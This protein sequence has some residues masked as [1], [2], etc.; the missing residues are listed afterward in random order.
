MGRLRLGCKSLALALYAVSGGVYADVDIDVRVSGGLSSSTD[1]AEYVA[2]ISNC[3]DLTSL[4]IASGDFNKTYLPSETSRVKG[5]PIACQLPFKSSGVGHLTT[6]ITLNFSDGSVQSHSE[7]F[8]SESTPPQ[9]AFSSVSLES[10]NNQQSLITTVTAT[11]D[12][13]I[14]FVRFSVDGIRASELRA[15]GGVVEEARKTA[16][17]SSAGNVRVYPTLEGQSSFSL[18]LPVENELDSDAI[19]HDGVVLLNLTAVDASGNQSS[20]SKI[21]FTGDDVAEVAQDLS[22]SPNKIVFTNL[23]ETATVIPSVQFQFRGLTALPGAGSGAQY[24]SSRPDLIAV[25]NG[26]VIY[27]LAETL[28]QPVVI[29]VSY[30]GLTPIDV[31]V[32]VDV[33]KTIT[34][35]Q[36]DDVD[37][38]GQFVINRL[39]QAVDIPTVFAV[40]SDGS[41]TEIGSQF[42][43]TYTLGE[44][45]SGILE[46]SELNNYY[47]LTAKA[48]ITQ[49]VPATLSISLKHQPSVLLSLPVHADDALPD[50][51]LDVPPSVIAG[52]TIAL[53]AVVADDVGVKEVQF[54]MDGAVVGTRDKA[55]YSIS[56]SSTEQ[57]ANRTLKFTA[58]A[59]DTAG[60]SNETPVSLVSIRGEPVA[61]LPEMDFEKPTHMQRLVEGTPMRMQVA[62]PFDESGAISYMNFFVD[63]KRVG[64]AYFPVIEEREVQKPNGQKEK[65]LYELWRFSTT[66]PDISTTETSLS[67]H[68]EVFAGNGASVSLPSKL[69]RV[70]QNRPPTA[71][72]RTPAPGASVSVGQNMDLFVDISDDTLSAGADVVLLVNDAEIER[73]RHEELENSGADSFDIQSAQK[74][75]SFPIVE[76]YLGN[77]L[78]FRV[79]ILDFHEEVGLSEALKIPVK[80]DQ[81]PSVAISHPVEGSQFVA[82]LPIELRANAVDDVA[83]SRVDFFVN[84]QLVGSDATAPFSVS[85]ET[86]KAISREQVL[87]VKAQ[88]LDSKE[89]LA[90][91][92]EVSVTLGL[93]EEPP[94]VNIVSPS[95]TFTEGGQELAQVIEDSDVVLKIAGY[96]N[97]GVENL[98][99][100]GVRRVG[101]QYELTGDAADIL[102]GEDFPAQQ[103]PG[104]MQAYSALKLV[105][106]PLFSHAVDATFDLYPIEVVASDEVGNQSKA[107]LSVAVIPD[108]APKIIEARQERNTYFPQDNVKVDVQARD[109]RA[110]SS[111]EI[112]YFLGNQTTP[113][114]TE[115][116]SVNSSPKL[117]PAENVQAS[118]ALNLASLTLDNVSQTIRV[119]VVAIDNR[120]NRS[121]DGEPVFA[122]DLS[123]EPDVTQPLLGMNTPIPGATLYHSNTATF[124]W[125]AADNSKLSLVE[126]AVA[127]SVIHTKTLSSESATG[128]FNFTLPA[129]G[130]SLRI[131]STITDIYGNS[132]VSHWDYSLISDVPPTV[133]IRTPAAGSRFI[134]GEPFT[135]SALVSDNREVSSA[136][137]FIKKGSE[138]LFSRSFSASEIASIQAAGNYLTVAMRTPTRSELVEES[139]EI[140]VQATDNSGLTTTELLDVEILDD[141]ELP[142]VLIEEPGEAISLMPGQSFSVVGSGDDNFFIESVTP[143]LVDENRVETIFEW[144]TFSRKDRVERVTIPNPL[145]FGTL[146]TGERFYTDFKGSIKLPESYL[147]DVGK[148]FSLKFRAADRGINNFETPAIDLTVLGDEQAPSIVISK[149]PSTL[150]D[151]QPAYVSVSIRDNQALSRY[152]IY[153]AGSEA[154]PVAQNDAVSGKSAG[155]TDVSLDLSQFYPLPSGGTSFTIIAEAEDASGNTANK[156]HRVKIMPDTAPQLSVLDENPQG[157]QTQGDLAYQTVR[158]TD[159]LVTADEPVAYFPVYTSL[160]GLGSAGSRDPTGHHVISGDQTDPYIRF[161]YPEANGLNASLRIGGQ[162]YFN[163]NANVAN[164]YPR[165]DSLSGYL[166]LDLG[167]GYAVSYKIT[168]FNNFVCSAQTLET[169]VDDAL[170]VSVASFI[171]GS[172]SSAVITPEVTDTN[173]GDIVETFIHS[174][175]V[176][177]RNLTNISA[178]SG[179]GK[180]RQINP[181]AEISVLLTDKTLG[182]DR[183]AFI[184]ARSRDVATKSTHDKGHVVPLPTHYDVQSM[185]IIGHAVDRMS[186]Q[187]GPQ[188]LNVLKVHNVNHDQQSPEMVITAPLNGTVV[189]PLARFD[190]NVEITDNTRGLRSLQLFENR[191]RLVRELG[192]SFEQN[193]YTIPYEVPREFSGGTLELLLVATDNSGHSTSEILSLPLTENEPP[194]LALSSFASYKVGGA[195]QKVLNSPER[196]NYGEFWVRVGEEFRIEAALADDAGIENFVINRLN[197]DG[198]RVQEY[199][200]GYLNSCPALPVRSAK[201]SVE[202]LFEQTEATEYE[203]ILTDTF[204]NQS[205]RTFLVH[206]LTNVVPGIRITTPAADQFIVA[207]TFRIKVGVVAADDRMLSSDAIEVYAN[208]VRLSRIGSNVLRASSELGGS[209]VIEQ[210]F[211]SIYDDI[212]QN[213]SVDIANEVA[214]RSSRFAMETGYVMQVPSGLVRANEPVTITALIRDSDN[215]VARHEVTFLAA[216]DEINP[217]VAITKPEIGYGPTESSDFTL[218]Y[219]GYDNVKVE[220]LELYTAYGV[221]KADGSYVLEAFGAPLTSIAGIADKDHEPATTV[222]ID[223]PEFQQRIHVERLTDVL[224]RFSEHSLTGN[225]LFDFWV[226]VVARD[227]SGNIRSRDV[228]YPVRIDERP[229]VDIVTP[230]PGE[231][232]VEGVP[233]L[234][235]VNAFDD[236]GI[237]SIRLTATHKGVEVFNLRLR[238]PPY[239]FQ[240]DVPAFDSLTAGNNLLQLY[241]EA[242]DSYGAAF[243]DLD[244]HLVS[245]SLT[246]EIV[247][248]QPPTVAIGLPVDQSEITE[249][250]FMLVQVNGVDD[251]GLD[252]VIL[253]VAGLINGDRSFSDTSFPYEFLVEIPYGQAGKDLTLTSSAVELRHSGTARVATTATPTIIYVRK[254]VDA[255]E[256]V[257]ESPPESGAT[258]VEKRSLGFV[259]EASDNVRVSTVQAELFADLDQEAGFESVVALQLMKE[260]PYTGSIRLKSIPEYLGEDA[261]VGVT[262]LD[263]QLVVKARDGAGNESVLT[264]PVTLVRNAPPQVTQIQVLDQRGFSLGSNITEVTEGRGIVINVIAQDPEVGVDSVSLYQSLYA[265]GG[266]AEYNQIGDDTAAPYQTHI[267]VPYGKVGQ[268]LSFR[269]QATD[270]DGYESAM[271]TELNLTI[272]ADQPPTAEI[273]KPNNDESV[274]IDG[275]DIEVFVEAIDDLGVDGVDRVVFY[276]NDSPVETAYNAYSQVTGS[277]AQEHVY[278]AL[279]TPPEGVQGVVIHAVAYDVVGN[280]ARTQVVRVGQIEDT[281]APDLDVLAPVDGDILTANESLRAVVAVKDIGVESERTIHM[282]WIREKQNTDGTWTTLATR[283]RY[284]SRDDARSAGDETPVSDPENHYYIYWDDFVDGNILTRED[285]LNERVRVITTVSTPNHDVFSES[286]HE[287]GLPISDQRFLLPTAPGQSGVISDSLK[288]A[289]RDVYYTSVAQFKGTERTGALISAWS[290]VDPLRLEQGLGNLLQN[291]LTGEM[292]EER[293]APRTGLFISDETNELLGSDGESF[294]YSELLAGASEMFAGTIT[295][296]HADANF[297]LAAKSGQI[298]TS[299]KANPTC[300]EGAYDFVTCLTNSINSDN[301]S[302]SLFMENSGGE[303]LIFSVRNGDAQFGLPYLLQG[304]VDMPYPDVFGVA[305]QD[306]LALVANGNGGVQVID[307]SNLAAPYHVGY[308]KPNGFTRDV[309]V[310]D[311][312]AFIAASYEGVV[313]ADITDPAMPIVATLDTLGVANRLH[314]EGDKLF[315]TDMAGEGGVSQ[316]NILSIS[317][318][319]QP[320]LLQTVELKP[321]RADYVADGSYDVTVAGNRAYVSVHYSDQQDRPAQSLIEAIDLSGLSDPKSDSTV[322]SVVHRIASG[323]DF[324]VRGMVVARGAVQAAA[325]KRGVSRLELPSLSVLSHTP[326]T[327]ARNVT[328][329]VAS[330]AIEMSAVLPA[331]ATLTD[332]IRVVEG[333]PMIGVDVSDKF[334]FGFGSRNSA[335]AYRYIE[336]VRNA[337]EELQADTQYFVVIDSALTPLTGLG[338]GADYLFNFVTSAAGSA[339]GPDVVSVTPATGGIEGGTDIVVRGLNFGDNPSLWL[340]NQ[341]LIVEKIEAATTDDPYQRIY[342]KTLPNYA[343]PAAVK[344]AN[345]EGLQDI[346]IGAFTYVDQLTISFINPPVVR[347]N[348]SGVGDNVDVVGYGFHAGVQL[349]AYRSGQPETAVTN[350]V[351]NDRLRLYSSERMSWVVPDFGDSYRGFVDVEISDENGRRYLLTN[352]LFYGR[353]Q[354]DRQI[355][356]EAPLSF[357]EIKEL[358]KEDK[359]FV[360]DTL[361]LPPGAIVGLES[362]PSLGLIYVLGKGVNSEG[363]SPD[364]TVTLDQFNN[365]FAPGWISLIHYQRDA[366]ANAA[367]MHGLGYFNLPQDVTPSAMHLSDQQLYVAAEGIHFPF[368]NTQYEDQKLLLV[369]DREDRLPGSPGEAKDRDILYALPLNFTEAPQ[370]IVSKDDLLF[371][372]NSTDGVAVIS[373]ADPVKPM[374]IKILKS[375][376][377]NGSTIEFDA[378]D[379]HVIDSKLHVV[380]RNARFIFDVAQPSLPQVAFSATKQMSDVLSD[381]QTMVAFEGSAS[382]ATLYDVTRS[383]HIRAKGRFSPN[384]F[385][386]SGS[387]VSVDAQSTTSALMQTQNCGKYKSQNFLSLYDLSRPEQIGLL[388]ALALGGCETGKPVDAILTDD[389]LWV[390]AKNSSLK[391]L[392]TL[393]LDLA[394]SSPVNGTVGVPTSELLT[395]TFNRTIEIPSDETES[396]YLSRYLALLYDDGTAEG[397]A[398]TFTAALDIADSRRVIITPAASLA[399]NSVYQIQLSGELGSRRTSGLFDHQIRFTTGSGVQLPPQI[400]EITPRVIPSSGSQI[401]VT[402]RNAD[403][404]DFL[405]A[406]MNAAV[407]SANVVDAEHTTFTLV[408]PSNFAGPAALSIVNASGGRDTRI[409]AVQYVEPLDINSVSPQQGSVNGG[410]EI[411]IKGDGFRPGLAR[412]EIVV[413]GVD[414]DPQ[415][416]KVLDAN[417]ITA[418]TPA[419]RI[420]SNDVLVRLDNGQQDILTNAFDY[421]QPVQSNI[422]TKGT[423]YEATL[424]PSGTFLIAAAGSK[425]VSI[426]NIDASTYTANAENPLNLSHTPALRYPQKRHK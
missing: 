356:A 162:D 189:V 306:D 370:V 25:T 238:Q 215:A 69:V 23:L 214:R 91:S 6:Q 190:I 426:Y 196:V 232:V 84:D 125:R 76:E 64:E 396:A 297:V 347:V 352:A 314:L 172:I 127:G 163:V 111:L 74:R 122:F 73:V 244:K 67:M 104:A 416:I 320:R 78:T 121:D 88:A 382:P 255:P 268:T 227:A 97:V 81:P 392:D 327:D 179:N 254:D 135:V 156:S 307:I 384:G 170:G 191:D 185:S 271:S 351:D 154:T 291:E 56:V 331:S 79:R 52:A 299:T 295:E 266:A 324:A 318:P 246:V 118:F 240:V 168:Q 342:A 353:L 393:I 181:E 363:A 275:Q 262:Q 343:G 3:T 335:P 424:D 62:L 221:T 405:L 157:D 146:I 235:N 413:G 338:L 284:L 300:I 166:Q 287:V 417:T 82:G 308:I 20:F 367:P 251:V 233:L 54:Y 205:I 10:I 102:M 358:L 45:T 202:I 257:V 128:S 142:V 380:G 92:S 218:G 41:R 309:V 183:V 5:S 301:T 304:R 404:P 213:Y 161:N 315:V 108:Q 137:F 364:E 197:R 337:E 425:G 378:N 326:A 377:I 155:I 187:R 180:S 288:S 171:G 285:G 32:E 224:A 362:D 61:N 212:E 260:P 175:R 422:R 207:G 374:V 376:Q 8:I 107:T 134:E 282:E 236:V 321:A 252:R 96:D 160:K 311:G 174:I 345:D 283:D 325:G 277:F 333:D 349:R 292:A 65:V 371:V 419:G 388:D 369:Y 245:E 298:N 9:L 234:I 26:G 44:G 19:T 328:T 323:N 116:R 281:V 49:D 114:V 159:D 256:V 399:A 278:R 395:L 267:K 13:D 200:R 48:I 302:G 70:L 217:E 330:I 390:G 229:V 296:L 100:R 398:T 28:G 350:V 87:R 250:D 93:D 386:L 14:S 359:V 263:M 158:M 211:A 195:Y 366:L 264:R 348:Q 186:H 199:Q 94:V 112:K 164:V 2:S 400:T 293:P 334:A 354:T 368:I 130:D 241:V 139:I 136:N 310:H 243:G 66:V 273:V 72:I 34:A 402:V 355:S 365:Y 90:T 210:A 58:V 109:D 418:I 16:F 397:L 230:L 406:G 182:E 332:F 12:T 143:I 31:P 113:I 208:G 220:S 85:Y 47:R 391:I 193:T 242:I 120:D 119:E 319:Y 123:I 239:T 105:K 101:S 169:T 381:E 373:I 272:V 226:R 89:Q 303:L 290:S 312:F 68:A 1:S 403:S 29:S 274:I 59:I 346:V 222:N 145:T 258:V 289:A 407:V 184:A 173:T 372:A 46:V 24:S 129:S 150:Y 206:P 115:T 95:V 153:L 40:F 223:T 80:A 280:S 409:G 198:S 147:S 71:V 35:L 149:P 11:D 126:F 423:I 305:R 165:P 141:E 420:G 216:A 15:A 261:A 37:T 336:L 360:P 42:P 192:G 4:E 148:T 167:A 269:A 152:K 194:Q 344:V 339:A 209:G 63:G 177:S 248:D 313:I 60:Q 411:T 415:T 383:N 322:P 231:K 259:I 294:V 329:D 279:I 203:L 176:D 387:P 151:S 86:I 99:L 219:R 201:E 188:S 412:V 410:T 43:I 317:D 249:G 357:S 140:G 131:D 30:P 57:M 340:A 7:S 228:S 22:V 106:T 36:V 51:S 247:Q 375:G 379:L 75:F 27:P 133:S 276:V 394:E 132:A 265:S 316:L 55:P 204:G 408:A 237:D 414:V 385:E 21:A 401:D 39:N 98:E 341:Q 18:I 270:I 50:V 53:E 286:F 117:I 138:T 103:I 253:H 110:V 361:K 77:T 17:T 124:G 144:E 178:Y 83:V 33:S 389:G 38:G 225:E 421:Q